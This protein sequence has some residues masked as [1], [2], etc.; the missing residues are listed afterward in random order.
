MSL[1]SD[2]LN[3]I[4]YRPLVGTDQQDSSIL[5]NLPEIICYPLPADYLQFLSEFP[6]TGNFDADIVC[7]GVESAPSA[8]DNI[9]P[10]TLLYAGC[11]NSRND[12]LKLRNMQCEIPLYLLI[13]GND[14]G[15]NYFCLDLRAVSHGRVYFLFHE[16]EVE[17]GLYLLAND[18]TSFIGTLRR[19]Q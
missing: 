6:I 16:E 8:P 9:Y 3:D 13:I 17:T 10:I 15:G 11:S 19:D 5:E 2:K 7:L 18:F 4:G 14:D 12:L 1:I